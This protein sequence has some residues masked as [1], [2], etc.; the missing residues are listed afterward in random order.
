[1]RSKHTVFRPPKRREETAE[2][3]SHNEDDIESRARLSKGREVGSTSP[4]GSRFIEMTRYSISSRPGKRL[5]TK[6]PM[7]SQSCRDLLP[8]P[9]IT[10]SQSCD[11]AD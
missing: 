7:S 8:F 11:G 5:S 10:T 9:S 4:V 2:G 3:G 1:M 6:P